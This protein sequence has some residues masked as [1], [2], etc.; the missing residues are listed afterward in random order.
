VSDFS[1]HQYLAVNSEEGKRDD[2]D[3]KTCWVFQDNGSLKEDCLA[4]ISQTTCGVTYTHF[5]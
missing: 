5:L 4:T 1:H 2:L 3:I